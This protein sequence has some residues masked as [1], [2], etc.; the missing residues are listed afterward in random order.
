[1]PDELDPDDDVEPEDAA[2]VVLLELLDEFEPQPA[3]TSAARTSAPVISR[4]ID[5]SAVGLRIV[6]PPELDVSC[7]S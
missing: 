1:M 7:G 3:S 6:L 4:R 5:L 2:G